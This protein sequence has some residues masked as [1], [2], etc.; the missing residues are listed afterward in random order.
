MKSVRNLSLAA[1]VALLFVVVLQNTDEVETKLLF[2]TV[3]M[4]R[5]LL[6]FVTF[7]VGILVGLAL[8]V[9]LPSFGRRKT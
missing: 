5:A 1:L 6:L 8:G 2:A 4:P 9:K 3:T 7:A